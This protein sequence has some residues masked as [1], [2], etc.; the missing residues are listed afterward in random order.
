[1]EVNKT[2]LMFSLLWSAYNDVRQY[3]PQKVMRDL[4]ITYKNCTTK[5]IGDCW[6]FWHCENIPDELPPFLSVAGLTDEDYNY[7]CK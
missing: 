5:S 1:M 6:W 3:H 2:H 4:G 7:W